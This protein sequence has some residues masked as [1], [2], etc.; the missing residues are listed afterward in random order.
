MLVSLYTVRVKLGILGIEDYGIYEVAGGI[1]VLFT[2]L[3]GA[4]TS[5]TQRFLN[6]AIGQNDT[7]Q[8]RNVFSISFIIYILIAV[9]VVI[10]AET[11][12]LW[13]F[14]NWL[15][16]PP[17]RQA[18][19]FVVY[20]FSVVATIMGILQI[21]YRAIIIAYEKM[22]FFALL[23]IF[24]AAFKLGIVFLLSIILF[25]KLKVYALLVSIV[26]LIIFLIYKIYCN[27]MFTISHF[28]YCKE[29]DLFRQLAAFSGW[30]VFGQFAGVCG[31]KGINIL[32]N[33]FHGVTMNAA[34][35]IA[36]QVNAAVYTFVS[37][38][39][40][41]FKPQIIKS[42]A[43]EDNDY[44]MRL[45]FRSSKVSYY[46]LF[47]FVL[48]LYINAD[49]VLMIWLKNVPEYSVIFTQLML[50][51]SLEIA[52]SGPLVMAIQATGKIKKYQ[53]IASCL[54]FANLP[55]SFLFLHLGFSPAW[56]LIIKIAL[57]AV[58]FLWRIFYLREMVNLPV[59]AFLHDVIIPI[60]IITGISSLVIYYI[61]SFFIDWAKLLLSCVIST[62]CIGTLVYIFGINKQEK[63]LIKNR[64][65]ISSYNINEKI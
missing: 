32:I 5:A 24:E 49:F 38:F 43:A 33:I 64:I 58:T 47:F 39:Q 20:Q 31:R 28:R 41:A 12:G 11:A 29:K 37:N 13:F 65:K 36:M 60:I 16:I 6:F 25:D 34:M 40:T 51:H 46:L 3:N 21:P 63:I 17:E 48:P 55:L 4:M 30:S 45:I 44:F 9:L 27:R 2:F 8:A 62:L 59:I 10:L 52:V 56:V 57:N 54:I 14:Y 22:S 23:S 26:A 18:A 15:N 19:A 35:G 1:V 7:E 53:L 42:Y 61:S 50:L